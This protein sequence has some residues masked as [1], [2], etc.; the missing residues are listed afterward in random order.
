MHKNLDTSYLEENELPWCLKGQVDNKARF[1]TMGTVPVSKLSGI[2]SA[3][4]QKYILG[5]D[6]LPGHYLKLLSR[7]GK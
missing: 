3:A 6:L 4:L 7:A 1:R 5:I 2:R